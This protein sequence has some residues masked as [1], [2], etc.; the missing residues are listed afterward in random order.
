MG[1]DAVVF[2]NGEY[3]NLDNIKKFVDLDKTFIIGV[4]GGCNYLIQNK[5]RIDLFVGDFDSIENKS[6]IN[7]GISIEKFNMDYSDFEIAINF[8]IE[9][10]FKKIYLL[11]CTGK[12]SDHFIFNLRLMEKV[13]KY[14]IDVVM[15]DDYNL[16]IPFNGD[17][18]LDRGEFKFFSIVPLEENTKISIE[19]SKY[20]VKNQKLD[21]FR[22]L[23]LSNEWME[24]KV[25]IFS[26]KTA[27][28]HLVF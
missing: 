26:D 8:C 20:D 24:K 1:S 27:F 4:D 16:I 17:K 25:K 13:F 10:N 15:I 18:I 2:C 21:M 12:R 9:N 22:A 23:T 3:G 5:I 7:E 11:G 28:L 14:G 19:G 6:Y